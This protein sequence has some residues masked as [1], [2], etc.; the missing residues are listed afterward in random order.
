METAIRANALIFAAKLAVFFMSNSRY[1]C[2]WGWGLDHT[3]SSQ[4]PWQ[5]TLLLVQQQGKPAEGGSTSCP[6]VISRAGRIAEQQRFRPPA[7]EGP[8]VTPPHKA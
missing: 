1:V 2:V 8:A 6:V 5:R 4:S 3:R 7:R